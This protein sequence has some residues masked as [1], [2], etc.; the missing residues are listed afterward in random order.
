ML[1]NHFVYAGVQDMTIVT[2]NRT[3][4]KVRLNSDMKT[5]SGPKSSAVLKQFEPKK[6][7]KNNVSSS[8]VNRQ[9]EVNQR[10]SSDNPKFFGQSLNRT[11]GKQMSGSHVVKQI[12]FR[13]PK[14]ENFLKIHT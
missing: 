2:D 7:V 14:S 12:N 10:K 5:G 1:N 13:T 11:S 6:I 8:K 9:L 3:K 4:F